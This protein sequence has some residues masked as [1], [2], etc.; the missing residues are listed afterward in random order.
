MCQECRDGKTCPA[1]GGPLHLSV[2]VGGMH[3]CRMCASVDSVQTALQITRHKHAANLREIL[4]ALEAW[5]V[6]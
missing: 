6:V 5:S 3:L 1:C 2:S 4:A